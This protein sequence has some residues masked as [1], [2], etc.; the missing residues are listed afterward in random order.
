MSTWRG[1]IDGGMLLKTHWMLHFVHLRYSEIETRLQLNN[2][3]KHPIEGP[4]LANR[5]KLH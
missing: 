1:L 5:S 2:G 4:I 3:Y